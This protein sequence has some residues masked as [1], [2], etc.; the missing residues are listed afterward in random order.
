MDAPRTAE[1][2]MRVSTIWPATIKR[3]A[4]FM[5]TAFT[6]QGPSERPSTVSC[7]E[8]LSR[9]GTQSSRALC[10]KAVCDI[11]RR[12]NGR[13]TAIP[14]QLEWSLLSLF[15]PTIRC[16]VRTATCENVTG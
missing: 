10:C 8:H 12:M 4:R 6:V 16:R 13:P 3:A 2:H 14:R 7:P 1:T 11:V 9:A 5:R 15:G